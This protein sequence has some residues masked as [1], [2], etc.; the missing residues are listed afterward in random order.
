L[1]RKARFFGALAQKMRPE[2]FEFGK[3]PEKPEKNP[4]KLDKT[5]Q[6]CKMGFQAMG[7][8]IHEPT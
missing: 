8:K 7:T 2:S 1:E 3:P 6:W 5:H 4:K